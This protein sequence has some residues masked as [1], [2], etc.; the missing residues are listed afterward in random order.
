MSQA[1]YHLIGSCG[2]FCSACYSYQKGTCLGCGSENRN[3]QRIS[4]W[5][6]RIRNC[7]KQEKHLNYCFECKEFPCDKILKFVKS[8]PKDKKY[9]YRHQA[10]QN[11]ADLKAMGISQWLLEQQQKYT[12]GDCGGQVI[13]YDDFCVDCKKKIDFGE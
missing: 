3:Q 4:K 2:I 11:L 1:C 6:C 8:H 7:C 13:F 5:N 9:T 12:C 10:I